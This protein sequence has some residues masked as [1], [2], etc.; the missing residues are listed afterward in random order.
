MKNDELRNCLDDALSGIGEDPWLLGKVLARAESGEDMKKRVS[1]GTALIVLAIVLL[2]SAAIAAV[3][4]WNVLDFLNSW[5]R[6]V[7]VTPTEIGQEAETEHAAL[8]VDSAVYDGGILAFDWTLENKTPET[9]FWC[10]VEE[11]TV[12]GR[13]YYAG[14]HLVGQSFQEKWVPGAEYETGIAR[15]GEYIQLEYGAAGE[16]TTHVEMKVMLYRPVRPVAAV[17]TDVYDP[18]EYQD[19][20]NRKIAEGYYVIP[21]AEYDPV[22]TGPEGYLK[23]ETDDETVGEGW[24]SYV[25]GRPSENEMGGMTV[26]TLEIRFDAGKT[27]ELKGNRK[28]RPQ[29]SYGNEYCTAAYEQADLSPLGLY[30]TLRVTPKSG[31]FRPVGCRLTDGQGNTLQGMVYTPLEKEELRSSG[32][33]GEVV[34]KYRWD[35]IP[36]ENLPDSISLTCRLE[37]GEDLVFPVEVIR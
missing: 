31:Q 17:R 11:F 26:E 1:L 8:R 9:P 22:V 28:L 15:G 23:Y 5:G 7:P 3:S 13:H 10:W 29:A 34:W 25:S 33:E 14:D 2:M 27:A 30:L 20:V 35:N 36:P 16:E 4:N 19:E 37:N 24:M 12:N 6:S 18:K 21:Y 32:D